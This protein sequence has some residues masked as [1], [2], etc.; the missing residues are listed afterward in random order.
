MRLQREIA[1]SYCDEAIF[2]RLG[3]ESLNDSGVRRYT[4]R[5]ST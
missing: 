2:S 4:R 5:R 1:S 3:A